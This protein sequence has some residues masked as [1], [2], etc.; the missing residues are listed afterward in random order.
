MITLIL[1]YA[2]W[3]CGGT[4]AGVS[5]DPVPGI[6]VGKGNVRLRNPEGYECCLGQWISQRHPEVDILEQTCPCD[7][8]TE[9]KGDLVF[10]TARGYNNLFST[11]AIEINDNPRT[12]VERKIELLTQLCKDHGH[13]LKVINAPSKNS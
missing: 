3:R 5:P 8:G 7:V 6:G 10:L 4:G 12:T 1:D 13:K 2:K 9:I 11:E